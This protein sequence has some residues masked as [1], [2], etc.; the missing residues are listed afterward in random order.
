MCEDCL[1]YLLCMYVC[2][3]SPL[4]YMCVFCMLSVVYRVVVCCVWSVIWTQQNHEILV[5]DLISLCGI[6]GK[7]TFFLPF[8][9]QGFRLLFAF[10]LKMGHR[11]LETRRR[12]ACVWDSLIQHRHILSSWFCL[13]I[14]LRVHLSVE[15]STAQYFN[16]TS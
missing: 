9:H 10:F 7:Q 2:Y 12:S 16:S 15:Y 8:S 4:V 13:R 5:L 1:L 6:F 11:R 14:T 3:A